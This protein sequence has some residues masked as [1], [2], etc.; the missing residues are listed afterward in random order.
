MA[1]TLVAWLVGGGVPVLLTN[2]VDSYRTSM[3]LVP[4][5]VWMAIGIVEAMNQARRARVPRALIT[6]VPLVTA[7]VI[8]V[9][10]AGS[11]HF[12]TVPPTS[13]EVVISQLPPRLLHDATIGVEF[14]GFRT[15]AYT[16]VLLLQRE[17]KGLT[18]PGLVV[19]ENAYQHLLSTASLHERMAVVESL[20]QDLSNDKPV[21]LGPY[22]SMLSTLQELSR[23]GF[24]VTPIDLP[25]LR[26]AYVRK[27]G[28][29]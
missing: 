10:R 9:S 12:P 25:N 2:R 16:K 13:T 14:M 21:I 5:A 29:R 28:G 6:S 20:V 4:L 17:Q 11:L 7:L 18:N 26:V 8:M 3:L 23:L 15:L 27:E 19:P 22:V 24:R 1:L